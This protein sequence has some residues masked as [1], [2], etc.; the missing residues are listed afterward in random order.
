M[1]RAPAP[2][3]V[4]AAALTAAFAV[5]G[6]AALGCDDSVLTKLPP[7]N[8]QTD[9][10]AQKPAAKVDI[11]WAIDSSGSFGP[12]QESVAANLDQFITNFTLCQGTGQANDVCDFQMQRCTVSG[13][14]CHPP[15]YH[16]G[17]ITLDGFAATDDGRLR[18]VGPCVPAIGLAPQNGKQRWCQGDDRH[19]APDPND[20]QSDPAN[21]KCDM[22]QGIRFIT[23]ATGN[24]VG[25]Y[26]R[27]IRV[28][29]LGS[30]V[31]VG[32]H[33]V[34]RAVGRDVDRA[35]PGQ[36]LPPPTENADFLRQ[37]ASLYVIFLSDEDDTSFGEVSYYYRLLTSLKGAGNEGLVT[38]SAITGE[39]VYT[40]AGAAMPTRGG[41]PAPPDAQKAQAGT[42][43]V[44]L[45]MYS[46]GGGAE[47]RTCDGV[48]IGCPDG[49]S[50]T[51][52]I[53][54]IPGICIPSGACRTDADCGSLECDGAGCISCVTR[55]ASSTGQQC[56]LGPDKLLSLLG[57]TGVFGS[58]CAPD[59]GVV[60]G[61]LGFAAAGLKRKFLLSKL[62]NCAADPVPCGSGKAPICVTVAGQVI[63]N[64]RASGWTYELGSNAIFFDGSFIPPTNAAIQI[65]Y[66][67]SRG[68]QQISCE[69]LA[70]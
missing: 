56:T 37:D 2:A 39:P 27:L 9:Q 62:P 61:N 57:R 8:V 38:V 51:R 49:Q 35:N 16:I 4:R 12:V 10:L 32:L 33:T 68:N 70:K 23:P 28:G 19:C 46:R 18:Q 36:W 45:A 65:T 48:R 24:A 29:T 20:P 5:V 21:T 55:T 25:A 60:L 1:R 11:L 50:C 47:V 15:D 13:A 17:V 31:E 22:T 30:G 64:D 6:P 69:S 7:S 67:I 41:C 53:P 44:A 3:P 63:P 59:Y 66:P 42:R 34:A 40:P 43:Y 26:E 14:A 52:P 54:Q 58:L